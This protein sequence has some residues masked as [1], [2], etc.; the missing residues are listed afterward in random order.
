VLAQ[1]T[2]DCASRDWCA[3]FRHGWVFRGLGVS[4]WPRSFDPEVLMCVN[5]NPL[6]Y[7]HLARMAGANS[8]HRNL[9]STE[10]ERDEDGI[11]L[12]YR[13]FFNVSDRIN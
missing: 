3:D 13:H 6:F 12:I 9:P 11:R 4:K 1:F 5:S 7:R 10:P 8:D 2:P